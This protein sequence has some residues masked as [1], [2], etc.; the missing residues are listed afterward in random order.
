MAAARK[1]RRGP[2][3]TAATASPGMLRSCCGVVSVFVMFAA[4]TMSATVGHGAAMERGAAITDSTVLRELDPVAQTADASPRKSLSLHRM[5]AAPAD[6]YDSGIFEWPSMAPVRAALD[7]EFAAYAARQASAAKDGARL[8]LL[9]RAPLYSTRTRFVL[10]G[11]VNRMDRAYKSPATCGEIRLIYR[12]VGTIAEAKEGDAK[13]MR[14]PMTL[15]LVLN[16]RQSADLTPCSEIARRWLALGDAPVSG[17]DAVTLVSKGGA[18]DFATADHIDRIETNIQIARASDNPDD[19]EG[20][21]DYLMKVFRFDISSKLFIEAAMENQVDHD[22]LLADAALASDFRNWLLAPENFAALD[23]GTILIPEKFLAT[24]AVVVTPPSAADENAAQ[25]ISDVSIVE[26]LAN[27]SL[28]N[29]K[30]QNVLS[31]AGFARRLDDITCA[32]CHRTRAIGGFHFPGTEQTTNGTVAVVT[33]ASPH[34]VGDQPRR[35]DILAAVR[36]GRPP[37]FSRGFSARPQLRRS[38]ELNGTTFL[39]GWGAHCHAP[40][41]KMPKADAS[42]ATWTCIDGL[43]CLMPAAVSPTRAGLCFPPN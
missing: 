3:L 5:L 19:F 37:D 38:G 41:V 12:P 39:N 8:R 7:R 2:G 28:S 15:N 26:A 22:K 4:A 29:T 16:A 33:P 40:T 25:I 13:P 11:I 9:D 43:A 23:T 14:L 32:G 10:V 1:H 6:S 34:F 21:A 35:R 17:N 24:S 18:L 30:F 42:F 36:D 31:P 27:A 20:R